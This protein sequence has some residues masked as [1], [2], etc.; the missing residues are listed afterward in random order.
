MSFDGLLGSREGLRGSIT[1]I[2]KRRK[3]WR[4][5]SRVRIISES[6]NELETEEIFMLFE[7]LYFRTEEW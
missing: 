4:W 3:S 7:N 1:K 5:A 2:H 6:V